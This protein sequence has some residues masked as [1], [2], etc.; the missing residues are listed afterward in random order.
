MIG[1]AL[2]SRALGDLPDFPDG[3][4]FA[5]ANRFFPAAQG[6][7]MA[8]IEGTAITGN[9]NAPVAGMGYSYAQVTYDGLALAGASGGR[10]DLGD[11]TIQYPPEAAPGNLAVLLVGWGGDNTGEFDNPSGW[12]GERYDLS[13]DFNAQIFYRYIADTNPFTLPVKSAGGIRVGGGYIMHVYRRGQLRDV[14]S[15][16][17]EPNSTSVVV[18]F[19]DVDVDANNDHVAQFGVTST[20]PSLITS[21]AP[22][23]A[24]QN[25]TNLEQELSQ[26]SL[27]SRDGIIASAGT[28]SPSDKG[29]IVYSDTP[30]PVWRTYCLNITA[31]P[32]VHV[33]SGDVIAPAVEGGF[34][35]TLRRQFSIALTTPLPICEA[36]IIV[37]ISGREVCVETGSR[38]SVLV[39]AS[40]NSVVVEPSENST[41]SNIS[42]NGLC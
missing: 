34:D 8:A 37:N 39:S 3:Y 1:G 9:L 31:Y 42:E 35:I 40:L 7:G 18:S 10:D 28:E 16:T 5:N 33:A 32:N 26:T 25:V 11:M 29:L 30:M 15:T 12:L 19:A 20:A 38:N 6:A 17:G 21:G 14:S 2:A 36:E 13:A 4:V 23:D 22:Y 27:W 24:V 41:V